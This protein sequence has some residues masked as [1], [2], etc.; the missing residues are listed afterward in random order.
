MQMLCPATESQL[1]EKFW[2]AA[3]GCVTVRS[4][5]VKSLRLTA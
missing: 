5:V 1:S 3:R 2:N 4:F